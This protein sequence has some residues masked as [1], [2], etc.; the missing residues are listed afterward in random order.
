MDKEK[1]KDLIRKFGPT[2]INFYVHDT[3]ESMLEAFVTERSEVIAPGTRE[4]W[5]PS[6]LIGRWHDIDRCDI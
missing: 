3:C 4:V 2:H 6:E 5:K 1:R